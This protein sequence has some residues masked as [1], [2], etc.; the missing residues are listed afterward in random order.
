[1]AGTVEDLSRLGWS[2]GPLAATTAEHR[3]ELVAFAAIFCSF[4]NR[5]DVID[6]TVHLKYEIKIQDFSFQMTYEIEKLNKYQQNY[7]QE[8]TCSYL[9]RTRYIFSF[10]FQKKLFSL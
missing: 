5:V 4:V 3:T 9:W 2:G 1:M 10:F 6:I 8:K 7:T